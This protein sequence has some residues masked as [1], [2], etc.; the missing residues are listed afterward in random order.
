MVEVTRHKEYINGE[1][2]YGTVSREAMP[3]IQ[4]AGGQ[5]VGITNAIN[6][7]ERIDDG[8]G[9]ESAIEEIIWRASAKGHLFI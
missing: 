7:Q 2:F 6:R 8:A 1:K 9:S 4:Y 5:M 3:I